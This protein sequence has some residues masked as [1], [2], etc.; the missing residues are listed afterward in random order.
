MP[1]S[2]RPDR[3]KSGANNSASTAAANKTNPAK[4]DDSKKRKRGADK[5]G[6][7]YSVMWHRV[8]LDECQVIKNPRTISAHA[9]WS[10]RAKRRWCLSGTPLQNSVDDLYPLFRFLKYEPYSKASA[11]KELIRDPINGANPDVGYKRLR[12]VLGTIMLRRTKG[13]KIDGEPVV[14]LPERL[15]RLEQKDFNEEEREFYKK[16]E[17][18]FSQKVKKFQAEGTMRQNYVS[19][20]WMLLRLRQACNHPWLVRDGKTGSGSGQHQLSAGEIT[21]AKKLPAATQLSLTATLE[22]RLT[23][24]VVCNDVPEDP[25]V[26]ICS[27]IY[28]RQC[29]SSQVSLAGHGAAEAELAYHCPECRRTL[30]R[31]DFF[32]LEALHAAKKGGASTSTNGVKKQAKGA[33]NRPDWQSSAKVDALMALLDDLRSKGITTAATPSKSVARSVS[34]SRLAESLAKNKGVSTK[35]GASSSRPAVPVP[36][37]EKVIVFSQWTSMLDLVEIPLKKS[38]YEFRRL[39]GSMTIPARQAAIRDF[40]TCPEVTVMLVSLKAAS[41]G[42]NLVSANHVVVRV[43]SL[44]SIVSSS[45]MISSIH[46]KMLAF[47]SLT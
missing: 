37:M 22:E 2:A 8:V 43:I 25:V 20:L 46:T 19:M 23:E 12:A 44:W 9:A 26:S 21:A 24:C 35:N 7:L 10:L 18:E 11:F 34:L 15:V 3:K 40:S 5:G 4:D 17:A 30:G 39:D 6:P 1:E 32:G 36:T 28:C 41:L 33:L 16:L 13:S 29:V 14:K 47:S 42:V 31:H 38:K 45:S 27:H